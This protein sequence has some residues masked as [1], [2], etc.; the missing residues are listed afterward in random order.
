[1]EI[2]ALIFLGLAQGLT[3]FLPIS[4]S[5]HL[6]LFGKLFNIEETLFVSI[7][8]HVATLLSVCIVFRKEIFYM[9][10]H[11]F[12]EQTM[13]LILA[14][15][16]TCLIALLFM[17]FIENAFEGKFLAISFLITAIMLLFAERRK[18]KYP[19][20]NNTINYKTALWMGFIQGIAIFPGISRSGATI[21]AGLFAK[22][23]KKECASFSFLM[24]IPI[25][26]LSLI[27]EIF[28]ISKSNYS[29]NVSWIGLILSFVVAFLVGIFS[30]KLMINLTNKSNLKYFSLYLVFI[31]ILTV[32]L[33]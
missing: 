23:N 25:I 15:I 28:K 8:L 18:E 16:P 24:S 27:M 5:G 13:N 20:S 3:E 29:L 4:S 26:F 17:P 30:I 7:I 19:Y 6:V 21:S 31:A 1:M 11:P 22:T 10:K 14:T 9:I 12:S 33:L 2:I 32:V